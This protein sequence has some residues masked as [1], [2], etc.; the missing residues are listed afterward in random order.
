[1][2]QTTQQSIAMRSSLFE[3]NI[4]VKS[5]GR[6]PGLSQELVMMKVIFPKTK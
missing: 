4:H 2:Y 6:F 1:M 5:F 3:I